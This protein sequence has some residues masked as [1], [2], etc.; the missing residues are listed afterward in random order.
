MTNITAQVRKTHSDVSSLA[1]QKE[2]VDHR[3]IAVE[4]AEALEFHLAAAVYLENNDQEEA[5]NNAV[6]AY[7]MINLARESQQIILD[8]SLNNMV[9]L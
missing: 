6:R 1:I 8:Q 2:I 5:F 9:L 4:L 7:G 3:K